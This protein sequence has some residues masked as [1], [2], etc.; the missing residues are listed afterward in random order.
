MTLLPL[1][2]D[3]IALDELPATSIESPKEV[4]MEL[5]SSLHHPYIYPT[6]D[7]GFVQSDSINYACLVTPFNPRGSLKDLI[8]KVCF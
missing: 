1:P 4:L 6:L 7:L 5:L 2:R 3:C 8:Y